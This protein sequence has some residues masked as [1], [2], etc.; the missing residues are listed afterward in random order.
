MR[1]IPLTALAL[2]LATPVWSD[3]HDITVSH[4]ISAFGELKY[5]ADFPH[6][7]Y[8]NPDAPK[9]GFI[10]FRGTLASQTFDSLNLFILDGDPAQGLERIYDTL[11]QRA[12]DEPD[13][14]YGRLAETIEYPADR[15]WVIFNLRPEARF[16][17]GEAVTAED[18]VFTI[19]TLQT[20][21]VPQYRALVANIES[22]QIQSDT[23][24]K[25]TF[26][27]GVSTRDLIQNVGAVEILPQHYYETV[28]F[29]KSTLEPPVGSGP[30]IVSEV[31][32]GKSVT[33]CLNEDYWGADLPVNVGTYNFGCETYEYFA[34]NTAA[35]EA[36]KSGEY[37]FH[38]EFFSALWGTAYDFPAL[39]DGH[40]IRD[41]IPDGRAAGTQGWFFNTRRDH[42]S[43]PRVRE[44]IG[45]GFNFEFSN[46]TLFSGLYGRTDSFWEGTEMEAA[47]P[48]TEG[49]LALLDPFRDQLPAS[50][51]EDPAFVPAISGEALSDVP[52]RRARA[53]LE[54][55]GW[56]VDD[57]GVLRNGDGDAME[58][59]FLAPGPGFERIVLPF[60]SNLE[61]LGVKATFNQVTPAEYEERS[62]RFDFD[63]VSGRFSMGLVPTATIRSIF[64]SQ[65]AVTEGSFN[66]TGLADPVVDA[67]IDT[68]LA[69]Q[70]QADMTTA[71]KALDRVLRAKHIW[72]PQWTKGSHWIAY[73]D[74][75]G[76]PDIKPPFDRGDEFW[77]FEQEKYD[78]LIE[79]GALRP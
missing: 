55:A 2:S 12:W 70:S 42:L 48:I 30:Y 61:R 62:K 43:D 24:V 25:L 4:G 16:S 53:L 58:L 65:A 38:E 29:T 51:F 9:G 15:S 36:L 67:L 59:E 49:E 52:L 7:D 76:F 47:G 39:S 56:V 10:S 20:E 63:I 13:A 45:M 37:L 5:P 40:V 6:F 19:E 64:S 11:L 22:T 34:D 72:V 69:A 75:F 26:T 18:V 68:M 33:Y 23:R 79:I 74:V 66:F 32:P 27:E 73:W 17:D 60:A 50:V 3:S 21:A 71:A 44:A 31:Q 1:L 35:F 8:V 77:W 14:A 78:R 54:A 41:T 28:D 57:A 46:L